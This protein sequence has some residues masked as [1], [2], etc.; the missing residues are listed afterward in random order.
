MIAPLDLGKVG[1]AIPSYYKARNPYL[2][3]FGNPENLYSGFSGG[4]DKE[5]RKPNEKD[6][7][8]HLLL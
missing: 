2:S 7:L 8:V 3:L 4:G 1:E 6:Y 5:F